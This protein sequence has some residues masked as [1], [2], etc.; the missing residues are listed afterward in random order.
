MI[1]MQNVRGKAIL[2]CLIPNL[3]GVIYDGIIC[4]KTLFRGLAL[5]GEVKRATVTKNVFHIAKKAD[6]RIKRCLIWVYAIC[7]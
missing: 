7:K 5:I 4:S 1:R 3:V 2:M 6:H